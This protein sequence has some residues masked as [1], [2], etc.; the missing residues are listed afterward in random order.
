MRALAF[1]AINDGANARSA[2]RGSP[3][4]PL[5][6]SPRRSIAP[7][8]RPAAAAAKGPRQSDG[9]TVMSLVAKTRAWR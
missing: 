1:N 5:P 4:G 6:P 8:G 7:P 3:C 9:P 2:A